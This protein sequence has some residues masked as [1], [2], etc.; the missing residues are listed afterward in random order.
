MQTRSLVRKF[1]GLVLAGATIGCAASGPIQPRPASAKSTYIVELPGMSGWT[2][3]NERC[4]RGL[5]EG[6][7]SDH[8]EIYDYTKPYWLI[9]AVRAWD[10]NRAAARYIADC[11]AAKLREDPAARIIL[12]SWSTGS[13]VTL[14]TLEDL[15][16]GMQVQSI[17]MI[18]P[19]VD[20]AHDLRPALSHVRGHAF[21]LESCGD[22]FALGV[23]TWIVGAA[24]G[25]GHTPAA[26][27]IG[28]RRPKD[29]NPS[30][31]AKL[32]E[33]PY[34]IAWLRFGDFGDHVGQMNRSLSRE[35]LAPMLIKD[36]AV[37]S[38]R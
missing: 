4:L 10:H 27:M 30:D 25:G 20:P 14:W 32:V 18:Q 26:G 11:I 2:H 12:V 23:G 8:I 37:A 34:Q 33:M 7:V 19:C 3:V 29:A 35:V 28:F 13:A 31:Y 6:G 38:G 15:P 21:A 22:V 1:V 16:P 9:G 17:L 24:D 5:A 36:A